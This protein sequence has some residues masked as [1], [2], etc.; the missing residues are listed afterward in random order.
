[1]PV[2]AHEANIKT[3]LVLISVIGLLI[4][5]IYEEINEL[6]NFNFI[7]IFFIFIIL[8]K[9]IMRAAEGAPTAIEENYAPCKICTGTYKILQLYFSKRKRRT[10]TILAQDEG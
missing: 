4:L 10:I 2:D 8:S 1:M 3:M 6:K 7:K 9:K 5:Y